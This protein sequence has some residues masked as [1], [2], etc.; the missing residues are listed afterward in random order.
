FLL[1]FLLLVTFDAMI[2]QN[3]VASQS[4]NNETR[5]LLSYLL[6]S[7]KAN[8]NGD[9]S[10]QHNEDG[11]VLV[12][13]DGDTGF[14]TYITQNEGWLKEVYAQEGR[15][16]SLSAANPIGK[17]EL[18]EIEEKGDVIYIRTDEGRV[19]IHAAPRGE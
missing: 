7:A 15:P 14:A 6:T 11:D 2:Y 8:V 5:S 9:I 19:V 10:V 13:P 17:T 4:H 1:G 3:S 16:F 12:I 18:F